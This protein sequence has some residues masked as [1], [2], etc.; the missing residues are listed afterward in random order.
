MAYEYCGEK[1]A[2]LERAVIVARLQ[3]SNACIPAMKVDRNDMEYR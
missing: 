2:K 1:E 3:Y